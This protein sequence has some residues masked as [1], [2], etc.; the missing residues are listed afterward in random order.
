M[1]EY[2]GK[3]EFFLMIFYLIVKLLLYN[4]VL[5]VVN[6]AQIFYNLMEV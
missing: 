1:F 3:P 6:Y 4:K 5:A 2:V